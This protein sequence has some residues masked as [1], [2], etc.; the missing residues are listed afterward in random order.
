[1]V[2]WEAFPNK[3]LAGKYEKWL[4][5]PAA[6]LKTDLRMLAADTEAK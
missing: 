1:M 6:A 3:E 5:S 4:K 2:Y